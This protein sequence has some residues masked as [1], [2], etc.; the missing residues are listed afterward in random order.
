MNKNKIENI[1]VKLLAPYI[2][3]LL[4]IVIA[5]LWILN[6]YQ[7]ENSKIFAEN[8]SNDIKNTF[9]QNIQSD[10]ELIQAISF[11]IAENKNLQKAWKNKNIA[12]L[13]A[14]SKPIFEKIKTD[15]N[16]THFY[17]HN[18]DGTNFLRVHAPSRHSDKINRSTLLQAID[19]Q[20]VSTGLEFGT[21]GQ[22]VLR[23][24]SRR[25]PIWWI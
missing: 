21:F 8:T 15:D 16:I 13:L 11:F 2:G 23:F 7:Q 3:S 5:C 4:I 18:I 10:I 12:N 20:N 1:R 25:Q 9:D 24:I 19:S 22:F 14:E 17:F 6:I